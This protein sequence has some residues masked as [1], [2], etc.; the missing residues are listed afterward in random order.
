[1]NSVKVEVPR[2]NRFNLSHDVQFSCRFGQLIPTMVKE[3]LPGEIWNINCEA[4]VRMLPMTA[5]VMNRFDV[6]THYFFVP[7]R[8]LW[9]NW[10][11]YITNKD[12]DGPPPAYPYLYYSGATTPTAFGYNRLFDYMGLPDP[13]LQPEPTKETKIS[14]MFFAAYQ[15]ICSEYYRDQNLENEYTTKCIDGNNTTNTG[16]FEL[17][18]SAWQHDY[19]T[20]CLPFAQKGDPVDIPLGKI[21]LDPTEEGTPQIIRPAN[22]HTAIASDGEL[23]VVAAAGH[24]G[25]NTL[26]VDFDYVLDPNGTLVTEA[27]TINDLRMA[28]AIQRMLEI[29]ARGG[30]RMTEMLQA[31]FGVKPEDSRLQRP[32]YITGMKT[33]IKISEVLNTTGAAA[34]GSLPQGNMSGHGI[35]YA[36]GNYGKY[37]SKEYGV[38]MGITRVLPTAV[39]FQG[40]E[41]QWLKYTDRYEHAFPSLAHLGEQAVYNDELFAF[42]TAN[43]GM[44]PFGYLPRFAEYKTAF[45]RLAGDLRTT[46][47][48]WTAARNFGEDT[49]L[50]KEFIQVDPD[51]FD[52]IFA[53]TDPND[54][55]LIVTI[56]NKVSA[57]RPLPIFGTPSRLV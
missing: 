4:L 27:T 31:H 34:D 43:D 10:E 39:Y 33:P 47:N 46:L 48:Y 35:T 19:F 26:G 42:R 15:K 28:F 12:Y 45:N 17:R 50:N 44:D 53:D 3:V 1:M 57:V 16:L 37:I 14:A 5:P 13:N 9:D 25:R 32:E 40:I 7:W 22:D 24:F 38:I 21:A 41:R 36:N 49:V 51:N 52:F 54:D 23:E 56:A 30:T 11:P 8:L 55:K 29:D 2:L 20:S 18:R 6:Y